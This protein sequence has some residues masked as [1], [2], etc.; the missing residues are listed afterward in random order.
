VGEPLPIFSTTFNRNVQI[1]A[2]ADHFSADSGGLLLREI[3][4]RTDIVEWITRGYSIL[5]R[6]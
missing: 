1:E 5:A 3:M 6:T 4:E 2:I